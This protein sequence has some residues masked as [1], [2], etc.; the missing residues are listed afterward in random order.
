MEVSPVLK[1]ILGLLMAA[2]MSLFYL[3]KSST[4][5]P[6]LPN[7]WWGPGK[8]NL[9]ADKTVRQFEILFTDEQVNDLKNRLKNTRDLAPPLEGSGWTYGISGTFVK[10]NVVNYWLNKYDFKKRIAYLNKY[11]QYKT[12]IQGLDIHFIHVKPKNV[13]GRPVIPLLILHGWPGSV[14]EF[15]EIIPM[16][17][18]PQ[19]DRDFVF[20][21][22]AP[23]LPGFGFS[24]PAVRPGLGSKEMAVV[25]KNLMLRLGFDKF[26]TQGGDW[27]SVIV[28]QMAALFPQ[29]VLGVHS[30]FCSVLGFKVTLKTFLFSLFPSLLLPEED[31]HRLYPMKKHFF[32][33]LLE[34]GYLHIQATKPDTVGIGPSDSPASLAGYV[35]EKFSSATNSANKVKD[36]GGLYDKF[37]PDTLIDN[38][39]M[40]WIPNSMTTAMRI[41]AESF[42]LRSGLAEM[43]WPIKVPSACAQFPHE[44]LYYP[45]SLLKEKY[46]DLVQVSRM[47]RGGHF[48]A[49]EEPKLLSDDVWKF[50]ATVENLTISS[51][52]KKD[53][54]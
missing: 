43:A 20:E 31:H 44:L 48:A 42:N 28:G 40:Y 1:V 13:Q 18:T 49:L 5:T 34:T 23:S 9:N 7:T 22:I 25:L 30:N 54:F 39:M 47:P 6:E 12:N 50:V 24:S 51:E 38:L 11:D 33:R 4:V 19:A 8:E 21:V 36:D 41:Y 52:I 46:M 3:Q 14:R 26:Y 45:P 35:L 15:Y 17:T 32:N 16:L 27:G 29:H 37:T 10:N 2:V 53:E